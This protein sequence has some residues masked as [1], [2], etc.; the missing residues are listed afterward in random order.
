MAFDH[1]CAG[2][3]AG[4]FPT[5]YCWRDTALY[6]IGLGAGTDDLEWLLDDPPPRVLP[7]FG[8]VPAFG[9]VFELLRK[10]GGNLVTLLHSGQRTELL[11][12][13]PAQGEM[14]TT[15]RVAGAFD[16]KVGALVLIETETAVDGAPTARTT[17]QLLLRGEGGFGGPRPPALL[18]TKPPAGAAPA[19]SAEI[20]TR[21][22]QALLYRLSG[23]INP[24]HSRPDVARAAGFDRPILHGL[25]T[26]GIA[27]RA[28]L[29]ALAGDDPARFASFEARFA[30]VVM[31]G[32]TLLVE[33][34]LLEEPGQA[35][36]TV[37]VKET[38]DVA[39]ANA[40]FSYR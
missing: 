4:P 40:L 32:D 39:I 16:M 15:A 24:I 36:V 38:G 14:A 34:Y 6:A 28:A 19:F 17:W 11:R 5:S 30:K 27:A 35:A 22:D 1:G 37:K 33:G 8:V 12:P 7:T 21:R 10:T 29:K 18:R 9:P 25:C 13:F 31:P 20:P 23:D 2:L 3:A 26:Y